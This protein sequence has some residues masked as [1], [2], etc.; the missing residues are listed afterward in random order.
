MA[1]TRTH[2]VTAPDGRSLRATEIGAADAP[3]LVVH[4][5]TPMSGAVFRPEA[6]SA[7]RM[8]LRLLAYDRPGYGG[9][10]RQEGRKIADAAADVAAILDHLGV[11][12]FATYGISGGGPHALACAVLLPERCA[13][14]AT[15][16]GVGPFDAPDLD[17]LADMGEGNIEEF[18]AA[19]EGG[20]ALTKNLSEQATGMLAA[21]PEQ[22]VDAMRPHLSD[23]DAN[24]LTGELA[25]FLLDSMRRGLEPGLDGWFDDDIAFTQQWGFDLVS[26]RVP[27]AVWQGEQDHMVPLGHGRWL[28]S[29]VAGAEA[30]IFPEEGHLTLAVNRIGEIHAWLRDRLV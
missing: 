3:L 18:G 11:E 1:E 15:V 12:R 2:H 4:H 8:G 23:V 14:A 24:A 17:F 19:L 9:S 29:H 7:E 10:T 13:A 27:V 25:A 5:G 16:A 6:E 28:G 21:Q 20:E 22:L 26:T 30:S